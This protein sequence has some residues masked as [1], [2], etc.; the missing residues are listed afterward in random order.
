ML[1]SKLSNAIRLAISTGFVSSVLLYA[2]TSSAEEE[3][4]AKK[5][6][7]VISV[8]GS[9]IRQPGAVSASPIVS[10]GEKELGYQ[11]EP[12]VEQILRTLPSTIPGDGSNVN[13][14]S[15]GAATIN[16]RGLG[17]QRS[18]VLMNGRRMIPYNYNGSVDSSTIPTA[19][20][21]RIDIITGGASAVYGSDAIAGAVN[22]VL[23]DD[24]QG[25][26]LDF[27]HSETGDGDGDKDSIALTIG[28]NLEDDKGNVVLSLGWS[29]RDQILLGDRPLGL[30]GIETKT[31]A[32]YEQFLNGE[33]PIPAP[34]DCSGP[35]SV[36]SGGSTTA[37]PTRFA[38]VGA[39]DRKSVV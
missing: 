6:L 39:G 34:A 25:V 18:L 24:F 20:I 26:D 36:E 28:S 33:P 21:E 31:G 15:G 19:L 5:D 4:E 22:V 27:K 35:N 13:N 14:G 32:N 29:Q 7:E 9:R 17:S 30:L 38:I 23:K 12:E 16:L 11:Q 2:P 3:T 8:T 1:T 10:I 37:F